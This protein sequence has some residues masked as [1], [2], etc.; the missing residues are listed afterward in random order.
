[1]RNIGFHIVK[2]ENVETGMVI[3]IIWLIGAEKIEFNRSKTITTTLIFKK[4][5]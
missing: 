1:M 4:S 3:Q 5:K 2:A